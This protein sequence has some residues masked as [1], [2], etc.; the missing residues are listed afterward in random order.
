VQK[1]LAGR[2][3]LLVEDEFLIAMEVEDV[4]RDLGAEVVGPF[5]RLEP[6]L[7]VVH[8]EKLDGAVLDVRLNGDTIEP[9]AAVL[10]SRGVPPERRSASAGRGA[11]R[12]TGSGARRSAIPTAV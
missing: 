12:Q 4:L 10:I 2:R 8:R 1:F 11:P 5:A 7:G 3:I 6:A 9:V